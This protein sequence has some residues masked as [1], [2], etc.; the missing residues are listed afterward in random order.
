MKN[1]DLGYGKSASVVGHS[2]SVLLSIIFFLFSIVSFAQVKSS[3]D[4]TKIKIGEQ[5]TYKIEVEADTTDLV[6]FPEGQTFSPLE[7][8]ESYKIDTTKNKARFNLIKK[9]GT[10]LKLSYL[11]KI[12]SQINKAK[13]MFQNA[14]K[15]HKYEGKYVYCYCTKSSHFSY[16][17]EEALRHEINLETTIQFY[18]FIFYNCLFF[19][20]NTRCFRQSCLF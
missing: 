4:P 10:P 1:F 12:G 11:P 9:Y 3:V 6:I 15:K 8:I 14:I 20:I 5:M 17:V 7:M 16:V 13:Q 18:K 2:S 19:Q